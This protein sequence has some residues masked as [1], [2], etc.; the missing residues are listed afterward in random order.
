VHFGLGPSAAA[1]EIEVLW[2]SGTRQVLRDV[3]ADRIVA[4]KEP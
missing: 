4:V 3:P 1:K 2:P